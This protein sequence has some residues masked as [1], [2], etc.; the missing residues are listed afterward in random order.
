MFSKKTIWIWFTLGITACISNPEYQLSKEEKIT[1]TDGGQDLTPKDD[2]VETD[3]CKDSGC[4]CEAGCPGSMMCVDEICVG[5][6][7][8]ASCTNPNK[9]KCIDSGCEKCDKNEDCTHIEGMPRCDDGV[10]K[11]ECEADSDCEATQVCD[12]RPNA[13]TFQTC[14]P[15]GDPKVQC[16]SCVSDSQC[17]SG[18][19]CIPLQFAA[20]PHGSYCLEIKPSAG[21]ARPFATILNRESLNAG[22]AENPEDYCGINEDLT[23]CEAV[24]DAIDL[25]FCKDSDDPTLPDPGKCQQELGGRCQNLGTGWTCTYSC[26]GPTQCRS[27][28]SCDMYCKDP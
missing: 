7:D 4:G 14:A 19:G 2:L 10:C 22:P 5:C 28:Q 3:M 15:K 25:T 1:K 8:N 27:D 16:E 17:S 18:F 13:A 6:E 24:L 23:T 12:A 9:S 21:C 20:V 26:T 11:I